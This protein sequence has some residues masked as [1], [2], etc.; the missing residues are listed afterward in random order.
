MA[1]VGDLLDLHAAA[2]AVLRDHRIDQWPHYLP[3]TWVPHC[4]LG[5]GLT[6]PQRAGAVE[7]LSGFEPFEAQVLE[8][9]ITDTS[10]GGT[11]MLGPGAPRGR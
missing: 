4:T 2:G 3:G 1:P 11:T 10:T 6:P 8:I 7:R 5:M 9:G